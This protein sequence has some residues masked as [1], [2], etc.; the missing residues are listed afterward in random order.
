M[1]PHVMPNLSDELATLLQAKMKEK[2]IN[3][4]TGN[5]LKEIRSLEDHNLELVCTDGSVLPCGIALVSIGVRPNS[6]L[7]QEAGLKL[8]VKVRE[9]QLCLCRAA[10]PWMT[11]W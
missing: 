5:G 6:K 11:T 7:A 8:G 4:V 3:V 1:A 9:E 10:S 2:G